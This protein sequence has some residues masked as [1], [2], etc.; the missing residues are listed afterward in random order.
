MENFIGKTMKS[1]LFIFLL[2]STSVFAQRVLTLDEAIKIGLGES[3]TIKSADYSLES[4]LKNLEAV[5]LGLRSSVNLEFD[6]PSYNRS[7]SSQFNPT[8]GSEQ[9]YK[10]ETTRLESRLFV[11]QPLV[12]SNGTVSLVGSLFGR[13]QNSELSGNLEDFYTNLSIQ[14]RQPL[15]TFNNQKAN[16]ER[17]EIN[18]T[19]S[20]RNYSQAERDL[21]YE[22]SANF[23]NL[24]K[25]KKSVEITKEKVAQT[26]TSFQTAMNKFRAGLIAEVEALQLEVDLA[27]SKNELLNA[28]R[29]FHEAKNN[30]KLLIGLPLDEDI[31]VEGDIEYVDVVVDKDEALR[32]ALEKRPDL[33]NREDD[34][35][36]SELSIEET[37]ASSS[38]RAELTANYGINKNDDMFKNLF[39]NFDDNRSV[40]MTVSIPVFDWGRNARE[41]ESAEADYKLTLLRYENLKERIEN[42]IIEAIGRLNS[43]KAR[44]EVLSKSVLV[45]EKSYSI[46]L[47][48]FRAGT[49]TSFDLT[50]MQLKLTDA[51]LNSLSALIDYRVALADLERKTFKKYN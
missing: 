16:L 23:Y 51:K 21:I 8:L 29:S 49:I 14:L 7:L 18:L 13:K 33:L 45:A 11:N 3:F 2:L 19:K 47:E 22:V 15:F 43:A 40:V 12:F 35:Y 32:N 4:S 36:L 1:S 46:S 17:A 44:V 9:F 24:L 5:K 10:V 50:Q 37:D 25:A 34:I 38:I 28:E 30:F 42:E 6:I 31:D 27:A 48:R 41:V 20:E 26:D 39:N